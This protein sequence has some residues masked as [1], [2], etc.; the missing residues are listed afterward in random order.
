MNVPRENVSG[1]VPW[2]KNQRKRQSVVISLFARHVGM[3]SFMDYLTAWCLYH[4]LK[5]MPNDNSLYEALTAAY[6]VVFETHYFVSNVIASCR[7]DEID[8]KDAE[9]LKKCNV[10]LKWYQETFNQK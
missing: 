2:L 9:I 5:I 7:E 3:M 10:Y 4:T 8:S 1:R 6:D